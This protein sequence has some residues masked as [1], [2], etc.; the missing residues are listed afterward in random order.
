MATSVS[1]LVA[2]FDE[3]VVASDVL[4]VGN[5]KGKGFSPFA[6]VYV[7]SLFLVFGEFVT[8]QIGFYEEIDDLKVSLR[9]QN[10]KVEAKDI[11]LKL[12]R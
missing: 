12:S 3:I 7:S 9:K 4:N 10:G 2:A 6:V 1:S 5:E 8:S 11:E